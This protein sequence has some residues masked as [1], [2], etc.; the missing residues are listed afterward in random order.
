[1][2]IHFYEKAH[3]IL[4]NTTFPFSTTYTMYIYIPY[5]C[6]YTDLHCHWLFF[7]QSSCYAAS[8]SSSHQFVYS[9]F[10]SVRRKYSQTVCKIPL[11]LI[12]NSRLV[13]FCHH[14]HVY[15][16]SSVIFFFLNFLLLILIYFRQLLCFSVFPFL[17]FVGFLLT[18]SR[19]CRWN[20]HTHIH[21]VALFIF[22]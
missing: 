1:M 5:I 17:L 19:A 2:Y 6:I 12:L 7:R 8:K 16:A 13:V 21:M 9:H 10:Q 14:C 15:T 3:P 20:I 11:F 22:L 4:Y 18:E